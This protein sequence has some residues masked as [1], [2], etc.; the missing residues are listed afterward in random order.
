MPNSMALSYISLKPEFP[1]HILHKRRANC[2]ES[3]GLVI[4][5]IN[6]NCG[7]KKKPN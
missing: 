4:L 7:L 1:Y 5:T 3:T 6:T 2:K